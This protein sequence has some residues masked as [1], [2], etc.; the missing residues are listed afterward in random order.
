[1]GREERLWRDLAGE[2]AQTLAAC[3]RDVYR[4]TGGLAQVLKGGER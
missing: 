2:A 1:M 3:S 4:V